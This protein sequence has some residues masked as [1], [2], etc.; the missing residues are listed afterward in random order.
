MLNDVKDKIFCV[1][2][3]CDAEVDQAVL[4][5]PIMADYA[6]LALGKRTIFITHGH[7]YNAKNMPPLVKGDILLHGHTHV[8]ACEDLDGILY[9]NP[10]SVAI[11]KGEST[12]GYMT[13]EDKMFCWKKLDGTVFKTYNI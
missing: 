12:R 1:R 10:G 11:P 13:L 4:E 3:N 5:F 2:G 7:V 9:C 8:T 6:L